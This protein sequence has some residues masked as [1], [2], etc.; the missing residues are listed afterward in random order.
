MWKHFFDGFNLIH[1]ALLVL[2]AAASFRFWV[3]IRFWLPRYIHAMAAIGFAISIWVASALPADAPARKAGSVGRILIALALPAIIYFFFIAYGGPW[4][5][6]HSS[7]RHSAP[8]P[9]CQSPVRTVPNNA[10]NPTVSPRFA[11]SFCPSCG[12]EFLES[13]GV[14]A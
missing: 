8:C 4:A 9:F 10:E 3:R 6:F 7:S 12:R 1:A 14:D 13:E 2:A 11:D 5:A